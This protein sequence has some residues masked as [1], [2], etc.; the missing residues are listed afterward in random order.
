MWDGELSPALPPSSPT[1][2]GLDRSLFQRTGTRGSNDVRPRNSIILPPVGRKR[3][4]R[5]WPTEL[6]E[7]SA[8]SLPQGQMKAEEVS[9]I[10]RNSV[11][12]HPEL[13][14]GS[15]GP[16]SSRITRINT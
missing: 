6:H 9:S 1:A 12:D 3:V 5:D 2:D 7:H 11:K 4:W 8:T 13:C 14:Q 10:N 16:K 15:P